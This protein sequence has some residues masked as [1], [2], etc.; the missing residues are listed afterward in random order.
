MKEACLFI[1]SITLFISCSD[2]GRDNSPADPVETASDGRGSKELISKGYSRED[3]IENLYEQ[4]LKASTE[5]ADLDDA[6]TD[7][8]RYYDSTKSF[9]EYNE[10]STDYY[11]S[12]NR[13]ISNIKDSV[14]KQRIMRIVDSSSNR[15]AMFSSHHRSLLQQL[16]KNGE[17]IDGLYAAIK[18]LLT[19][20][21]IENYQKK[22]RPVPAALQK[23]ADKQK[24]VIRKMDS[25]LIKTAGSNP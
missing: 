17:N 1:L 6:L 15:Y 18:V 10:K 20:P 14:L 25:V 8:R 19:L 12:A 11:H 24:D 13:H 16:E 9:S 7:A 2:S 23:A 5:L 3:L 21:D 4:K 22:N